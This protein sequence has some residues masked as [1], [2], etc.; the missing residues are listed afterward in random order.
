VSPHSI[1]FLASLV[2]VTVVLV[3]VDRLLRPS[4]RGL[5]EEVT[6]YCGPVPSLTVFDGQ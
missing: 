2:V 3:L 5:L 1:A 4:L 6:G